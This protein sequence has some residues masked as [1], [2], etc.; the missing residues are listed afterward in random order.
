ME[1][2]I[3]DVKECM[4]FGHTRLLVTTVILDPI[5]QLEAY[6]EPIKSGLWQPFV[7]KANRRKTAWGKSNVMEA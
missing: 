3:L 7:S 5:A 1:G 4:G 6:I 2:R